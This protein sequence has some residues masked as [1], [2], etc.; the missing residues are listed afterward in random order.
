MQIVD[1][2]LHVAIALDSHKIHTLKFRGLL[3]CTQGIISHTLH[4][5]LCFPCINNIGFVIQCG[6]EAYI[7]FCINVF[8]CIIPLILYCRD[9]HSWSTSQDIFPQ[10][11]LNYSTC[12]TFL[13]QSNQIMVTHLHITI[14]PNQILTFSFSHGKSERWFYL[15]LLSF[16]KPSLYTI[17]IQPIVDPSSQTLPNHQSIRTNIDV[18]CRH[19][20]RNGEAFVD[21]HAPKQKLLLNTFH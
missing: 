21:F 16:K 17:T 20:Y 13:W 7:I 19:I 11:P 9:H 1:G 12:S 2:H 3:A 6:D 14:V 4:V 18:L 10:E 5:G 15:D 8:L